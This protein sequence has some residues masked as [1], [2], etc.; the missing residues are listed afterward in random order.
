VI[1]S[2]LAVRDEQHYTALSSTLPLST[3][4]EAWGSVSGTAYCVWLCAVCSAVITFRRIAM[5][6][7]SGSTRLKRTCTKSPWRRTTRN[8]ANYSPTDTA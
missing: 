1:A 7:S 8:V 4:C 6:S 3:H 2:N 5:P